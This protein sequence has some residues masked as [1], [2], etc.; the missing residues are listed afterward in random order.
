MRRFFSISVVA[1]IVLFAGSLFARGDKAPQPQATEKK[2]IDYKFDLAGPVSPGDSAIFLVG[3]F[4][5]QHNGAV[6]TC[7]SAVRYSERHFKF[8]GNVL[9]NKNTTYIY[10]DRA[11]YDGDA[12]EAR[13]YSDLIKVVDGD[14]TLY[15]YEFKFN[16]LD[17][18]GQFDGGGILT[19][20]ES[21]LES[22]RG[23]YYGDTKELVA[24]DEVQMRNEEYE[25]MG[26]S[27]VYNM[28]DDNA[29]FYTHTNIWS[30]SGD[31]LSADR[32]AY[33]SADT[34][35]LITRNGY[36]LTEKQEVWSDSIDYF[37]PQ[38]HVIL[39]HD[40]QLDDSE[41]KVVA[42]GDYGEYWRNPGNALLTRRPAVISYDRQQGDSLFMA[43]D[44]ISLF[45]IN[46]AAEQR[47]ALAQ[48][49]DSLEVARRDSLPSTPADG[50]ASTQDPAQHKRKQAQ[51]DTAQESDT[52]SGDTVDEE[53]PLTD[54]LRHVRDSIAS[55]PEAQKALAKAEKERLKEEARKKK[56]E[57]KAEKAR[58]RK[59]KLDAIA[60][61][62]REQNNKR[63]DAEKERMELRQ[64]ARRAKIESKL[65]AKRL[66]AERKG[67]KFY[68][69]DPAIIERNDSMILAVGLREDSLLVA[70]YDSLV[71]AEALLMDQDSL[72]ADSLPA[73]SIYRIVKGFR[74]VRIYRSD[75]QV[76]CDSMT[77]LST[78][79]TIHLYREP[80]LWN[81]Q[82]QI[83]AE[84]MDIYTRNQQVTHAEFI[85]SPIMASMIDT[86]HYNQVTGKTMTAFFRNNEIYR[87]DVNGNARTI[88][89][90]QDGEPPVITMMGVLESGDISFFMEKKE[91]TQIIYR[92]NPVYNFYPID[93]IP[94]DQP[95]KLDGFKWEA[96]RR[97]SRD[98][99]FSGRIRPSE[100]MQR[101]RLSRPDFPI[102]R[103]IEEEKIRLIEARQWVDR[104]DQVDPTTEDWMRELGFEVGQPRTS[105]P[106][107]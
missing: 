92:S 30:H 99:V 42:F 9:I 80:V 71:R 103:R 45:T 15:T 47:Q 58:L 39:R 78:D 20:R 52:E 64:K 95:L 66:K 83:T 65:R 86:A 90:M 70:Y 37:R 54:S 53:E 104:N 100:R 18:I 22:V 74:S 2:L 11:E 3:N 61:K 55:S 6:I 35:Y 24:V 12:N 68:L 69:V 46:R 8:F 32:G 28:A 16:T 44:T 77:M 89:Y 48:R 34:L 106:Q 49:V 101:L 72:A 19:N 60:A 50:Q 97:P 43:A 79:S 98:S 62:R 14:A 82:N 87:D 102:Q 105:G 36:I 91:M 40:I 81:E 29:F 75:F 84:V 59:E 56:E 5:A 13:I 88:Y 96:D 23:Y 7:D 31:Y 4:A 10:G 63:L 25:L 73:D 57:A 94:P 93:Q 85:G 67:R 76:A 41:H 27:V 51:T 21:R 26:D 17:N 107:L 33:H 1:A 38:E